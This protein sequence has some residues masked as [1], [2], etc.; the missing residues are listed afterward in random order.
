MGCLRAR[1]PAA[2]TSPC[3]TGRSP[4]FAACSA[5]ARGHLPRNFRGHGELPIL[6]PMTHDAWPSPDAPPGPLP[7]LEDLP[8]AEQG[9]DQE[10]VRAAFDS[11]YRHAA[12]LDASLPPL[13]A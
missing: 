10:A 12:Q 6:E 3:T 1:F 2:R 8:I 5:A 4:C 9:Y 7:R 11:F 13:E